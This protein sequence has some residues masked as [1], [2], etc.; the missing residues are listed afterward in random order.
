MCSGGLQAAV[1][2]N[3]RFHT[4]LDMRRQEET[5]FPEAIPQLGYHPNFAIAPAISFK[6]M[7]PKIPGNK[8]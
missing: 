2:R 8:T 1:G 4:S 3:E 6:N 7:A 5:W